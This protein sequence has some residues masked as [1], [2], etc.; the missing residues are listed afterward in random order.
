MSFL[1]HHQPALRLLPSLPLPCSPA[2]SFAPSTLSPLRAPPETPGTHFGLSSLLRNPPPGPESP[3]PHSCFRSSSCQGFPPSTAVP[4]PLESAGCSRPARLLHRPKNLAALETQGS[5]HHHLRRLHP[6]PFPTCPPSQHSSASTPSPSLRLIGRCLRQARPQPR[7]AVCRR[8]PAS[9]S[10]P[11]KDQL[12]G[13]A[14]PPPTHPR[15]GRRSWEHSG[16]WQPVQ[17]LWLAPWLIP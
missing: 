5:F 17:A 10:H 15:R 8:S 14:P 9:P 11:T 7:H 2:A 13:H 16:T 12:C 4:H 1:P 3:L 6:S